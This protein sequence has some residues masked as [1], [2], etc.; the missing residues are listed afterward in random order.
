M[1]NFLSLNLL[2]T[3]QAQLA[4]KP[5]V[6]FIS[7]KVEATLYYLVV[8]RQTHT[9]T[10]LAAL[11]WPED[12]EKTS[13]KNMRDVIFHLRKMVGEHLLITR[14]TLAFNVNAPYEL[15]VDLLETAVSNKS[16]DLHRAVAAYRNDFLT[17]FYVN[18]APEFDN[19]TVTQSIHWRN[20]FMQGLNLLTTHYLEQHQYTEGLAITARLLRAEPWSE[21][22][23]QQRMLL[24]AYNGQRSDALKTYQKCRQV[25]DEAFG[26]SP[27]IET[28]ALYDRIRAEEQ[29]GNETAAPL[30]NLPREFTPFIGRQS[31]LQALRKMIR[32]P[33]YSLVTIMGEGGVGK[34]R[35][36]KTTAAQLLYDFPDGVW[37]VPLMGIKAADEAAKCETAL[38]LAVVE[39]LELQLQPNTPIIEQAVAQLQKKKLLL[40][41][42]NMEKLVDG[43]GFIMR[44]LRE[45]K[46]VKLIVTSRR[47]LNLQMETVFR[48]HGLPVPDKNIVKNDP[49]IYANAHASVQLFSERAHSVE[50]NFVM[51]TGNMGAIGDI[52]RLVDGLPLGIELAAALVEQQS[53]VKIALHIEEGIEI[54]AATMRDLPAHHRTI[55]ALFEY[56]WALL[57]ERDRL[58]LAHCSLF[59]GGFTLEAATAVA[60]AAETGLTDLIDQSL[61]T[62]GENGRY[63][64]HPLI[65]QF[66]AQKRETSLPQEKQHAAYYLQFI[67][68]KA[69]R[70][71]GKSA[72]IAIYETQIENAN[73]QQGW[74]WAVKQA[75]PTL[76]DEGGRGLYSYYQAIA[77][78]SEGEQYM[79]QAITALAIHDPDGLPLGHLYGFAGTFVKLQGRYDEAITLAQQAIACGERHQS[80]QIIAHARLSWGNC[81][82]R[83]GDY[84]A[85]QGQLTQSLSAYRQINDLQGE[86]SVLNSLGIIAWRLGNLDEAQQ[87]YKA[88]L[89]GTQTAGDRHFEGLILTNL[90]ILSHSQG[91]SVAAKEYLIQS[92]AISHEVGSQ[93]G[94]IQALSNLAALYLG[95]GLLDEAVNYFERSLIIAREIK[96]RHVEAFTLYGLGNVSLIQGD[97]IAGQR[98][99]EQALSIR[100]AL[101]EQSSVGE[102]L[103][104]LGWAARMR[105]DYDQA[106]QHYQ[107]AFI[108]RQE[109]HAAAAVEN[110]AALAQ[111]ALMRGYINDASRL[112][113]DVMAYLEDDVEIEEAGWSLRIHLICYQ[114]SVAAEDGRSDFILTRAYNLL[115]Q[116]AAQ[117]TDPA[118]ASAYVENIEWRREIVK[119]MEEG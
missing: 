37:F 116:K 58:L 60:N 32:N 107:Q 63:A 67:N 72:K 61:L 81:L 117:F 68:G 55:W 83:Q 76:I 43:V 92:L 22:T 106:Q 114:V 56:S 77:L 39:A 89:L 6:N 110:K 34:S 21:Q 28:T 31:E 69:A 5:L 113:D 4:D 46:K 118:W 19:W 33:L 50:P 54:L 103:H 73:I 3:P 78:Y 8:T 62:R 115:R 53:C 102:S 47:R 29:D 74:R 10:H 25:L 86:S 98:Y 101:G 27:M 87:Y 12:D 84:A 44:L 90:S 23:Y 13:R 45:A 100:Q 48:L 41:M 40:V 38:A 2:G 16:T 108:I 51:T 75:D 14:T 18:D 88:C 57:S 1:T 94:E 96:D 36:A 95:V 93:Q 49:I 104:L 11:F 7:R 79:Q 65:Q 80:P 85:A 71:T 105:G 97:V 64:M 70:L 52:C 66:A 111:L 82:E 9:R 42:D 35:L 109:L 112:I 24:F 59:A 119:L 91:D 26:I 30:H 17:G 20:L 15:D 99:A